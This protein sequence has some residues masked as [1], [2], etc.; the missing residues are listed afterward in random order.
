MTATSSV[1]TGAEKSAQPTA[2]LAAARFAGLDGLRGIAIFTV[3]IFHFGHV[4][5]NTGSTPL[6]RGLLQAV[7]GGWV[8][9]EL[10]FVLS[11]FLITDILLKARR[12]SPG[13]ALRRFWSRRFLR[14][15]PVYYGLLLVCLF[16]LPA[17]KADFELGPLRERQLWLWAFITNFWP[18]VYNAWGFAAGSLDLNHTWSLAIEEQFYLFWPLL[19]LGLAPARLRLLTLVIVIASPLAR[20]ELLAHL[21]Q[22]NRELILYTFTPTR[23]DGL[24]LGAALAMTPSLWRD[25]RYPRWAAPLF[26]LPAMALFVLRGPEHTDA[27]T[28]TIGF[29]LIASAS[30]ALM[31]M[32]LSPAR[33]PWLAR[34]LAFPGLTLLGR[35]SYGIYLIHGLL[36]P[37]VSQTALAW[38]QQRPAYLTYPHYALLSFVLGSATSIALAILLYHGW[39]A[40]FLRL[41]DR[42][43]AS[44]PSAGARVSASD[45]KD[46]A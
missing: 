24:L 8:G 44:E 14:I 22:G 27:V 10:F 36:R 40:P 38:L 32:G 21:L 46:L 1:A 30:A 15:L 39:E 6:V 16:L 18:Y 13:E 7:H 11:G 29:S 33:H 42:I 43:A 3:L 35:Y 25:P 34:V 28:C 12:R 20:Y 4:D 19:V 41:K 5:P 37:W 31:V 2:S 23:L 45:P 26:V 17:L 9:V